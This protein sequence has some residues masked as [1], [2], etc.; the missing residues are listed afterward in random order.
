MPNQPMGFHWAVTF[1]RL[2]IACVIKIHY[3]ITFLEHKHASYFYTAHLRMV[4]PGGIVTY[5]QASNISRALAGNKIVDLSAVA[6]A[7]PT[8]I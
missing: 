1:S 3:S 7:A 4:R 6:G 5:R 8:G 2:R